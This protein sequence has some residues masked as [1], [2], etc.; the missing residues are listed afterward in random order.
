MV[1]REEFDAEMAERDRQAK[2]RA[3]KWEKAL[4]DFDDRVYMMMTSL[5]VNH[6]ALVREVEMIDADMGAILRS[7]VNHADDRKRHLPADE[8]AS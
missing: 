7:H 6:L 2:E 8:Q 5:R 4:A 1:T 3:D